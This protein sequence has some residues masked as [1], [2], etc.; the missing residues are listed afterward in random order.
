MP[1][2]TEKPKKKRAPRPKR[3]TLRDI[4]EVAGVHIMTVSDALN[5][6]RS[7]APATRARVK[8]IAAQMNYVPNSAAR[9]L[10]TGKTGMVVVLS[11]IL[12]EPYYAN[13]V[14]HLEDHISNAG[15]HMLVMRSHKEIEGVVNASIAVDGII[16]VDRALL[17]EELKSLPKVPCVS[18]GTHAVP[19]VDNITIDLS[20]SV[21]QGLR[22][23][24]D[25]GRQ[26]I[27]YLVTTD[28]MK[29]DK[30]VRARVYRATMEAANRTPEWI[31]V[32]ADEIYVIEQRLREYIERN[33]APDAL[34]CQNDETAMCA[35]H[36]VKSLG[37]AVPDD[38][39]LLG[40]D[41]QLHMKYFEPPLSTITQPIDLICE[42]AW[43]LLQRRLSQPDLPLQ[44]VIFEGELRVTASLGSD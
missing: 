32:G 19:G 26:R 8:E 25:A 41:G 6:T 5:N 30:E 38:L 1:T 28:S 3:V 20:Q 39:L 11:G 35:F 33:G 27:A 40:C 13:I 17:V 12:S 9:A 36:V 23:M 4:A 29:D 42:A 37:Y 15:L 7:V 18:I 44:N 34:F 31:N 16:A 10:V 24:L 21:A 22:L 43:L 14:H 2:K